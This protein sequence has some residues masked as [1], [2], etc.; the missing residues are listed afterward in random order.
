MTT[1]EKKS[2][3]FTI[4]PDETGEPLPRV[5]ANFCTIEHSPLDFTLT[6]CDMGPFRARELHEA[7]VSHTVRAPVKAR[8]VV[9]VPLIPGLIAA[10]QENFRRHQDS[11]GPP[12][13]NLH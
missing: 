12:P 13:G 11:F 3:D 6:F 10:L 7:Q 5:Y 2:I 4:V 9:P 1:D 8:L